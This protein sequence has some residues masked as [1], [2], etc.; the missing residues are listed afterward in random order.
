MS[1][2]VITDDSP[3]RRWRSFA[4]GPNWPVRIAT[5]VLVVVA[6]AA[7]FAQWLSPQDPLRIDLSNTLAK[8]STDH[9]LGTDQSGRD[10]ASRLIWGARPSLVGAVGVVFVSTILGLVVGVT[11]AWRGGWFDTVMSRI[12]DVMFSFPGLLLAILAVSLFGSGLTSPALALALAYMPYIAR[13]ARSATLAEREQPYIAAA[14]VQGF[15]AW[16]INIRHLVPNIVP[17]VMAQATINFGYALIDLAALSFLGLGIQPP[18]ADWGVMI[19]EGQSGVLRGSPQQ[20]L[21]AGACVVAT[22]V[23]VNIIGEW[24]SDRISRRVE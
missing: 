18:D 2:A 13:F 1:D 3:T 5:V 20:A 11:S 16:S 10:I 7:L 22:V 23:A 19:A 21:A 8:S 24:L 12:T 9:W 15:G 6:M 14:R 17:L 4:W